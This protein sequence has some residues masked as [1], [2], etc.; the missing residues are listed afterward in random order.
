MK[1][2]NISPKYG[3][4]PSVIICTCCGLEDGLAL[5]GRI[6]DDQEAPRNFLNTSPCEKCILKFE[7]YKKESFVIF[8]LS[9]D[10]EKEVAKNKDI[11]PWVFFRECHG[12]RR[13]AAE[14]FFINADLSKG[15]ACMC[16]STARSIGLKQPTESL[17]K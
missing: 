15:A 11:S 12:I 10:Y 13:E 8:V 6:K 5:N 3:L 7:S 17:A 9:D 1:D 16:E 2:I 4:N 14:N